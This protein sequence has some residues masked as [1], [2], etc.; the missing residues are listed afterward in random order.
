MR[1][2]QQDLRCQLRRIRTSLLDLLDGLEYE[3]TRMNRQDESWEPL[4]DRH[5]WILEQL[6]RGVKLTRTMVEEEFGIGEKQAKRT[7]V[8][9]TDCGMIRFVRSPR[10]GHYVLLTKTVSTTGSSVSR[11]AWSGGGDASKQASTPKSC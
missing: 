7:L 1:Y 10:P 2:H 11:S 4:T 9:L 6:R 3:M 5:H 8:V